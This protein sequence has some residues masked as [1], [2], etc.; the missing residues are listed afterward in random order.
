MEVSWRIKPYVD[1]LNRG[2]VFTQANYGDG[3]WSCILGR[4]GHNSQGGVYTPQLQ[5]ALAYTLTAP[6]FT[7]FGTNPGTAFWNEAWAWCAQNWVVVPWVHKEMLSAANVR[8]D[9]GPFIRALQQRTIILVGP[10]HLRALD[11]FDVAEFVEVPLPGA[12]EQCA[13]LAMDV[14]GAVRTNGADR[15]CVLFSAGMATNVMMHD[16]AGE[17]GRWGRGVVVPDTTMLD[18][19]AIWDPYV[20]V[21]SRWRYGLPEVQERIAAVHKE[22]THEQA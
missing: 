8:G 12:A 17:A 15:P 22:V 20:G 11:L 21:H 5:A 13:S 1:M 3:E 6:Q 2:Q 14:L 7:F 19:G 18:C 9:L 4:T 16:L 10:A